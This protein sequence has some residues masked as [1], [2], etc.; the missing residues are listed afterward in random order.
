MPSDLLSAQHAAQLGFL[1][2]YFDARGWSSELIEPSEAL[3]IHVLVVAA[4]RDR[5]GRERSITFAYV[6]LSDEDLEHI[7]L[8]QFYSPL[9]FTLDAKHVHEVNAL[10]TVINA[11]LP[12]G[13]FGHKDD[14]ELF[15]HHIYVAPRYDMIG[16][17]P[18]VEATLLFFAM[19]DAFNEHIEG[20]ATGKQSVAETLAR[21]DAGAIPASVSHPSDGGQ[22]IL[23]RVKAYFQ[24]VGWPF[25]PVLDSAIVA[26]FEGKNGAYNCFAQAR[27]REHQL[28][29]YA[30][31]PLV[32]PP[33]RIGEM[34][35]FLTRAN[36][37]LFL[38]NFELD[39]ED[40]EIRFK[41]SVGVENDVLTPALIAQVVYPN[42]ATMD[43]YQAGIT[44]II[45]HGASAAE[46]IE[47]VEL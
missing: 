26:T 20:V 18:F 22:S 32:T 47:L 35:E 10:L 27:E 21:L 14:R 31:S 16:E 39:L 36:R 15:L 25:T 37:G 12:I 42:L 34:M 11:G 8:L 2:Q 28:I 9:P 43:P 6:P 41:T 23:E 3:P 13:H 7:N 29:F 44:A 45:Q 5:H 19:Q 24:A 46:A 40:G 17:D 1:K 33:E 38:G 30:V 4:P